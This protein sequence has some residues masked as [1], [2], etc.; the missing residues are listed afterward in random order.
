MKKIITKSGVVGW[1]EKLHKVY[2]SFEEFEVYSNVYGISKRLGYKNAKTCWKAN[3]LI[4]GSV[5]PCD[6]SKSK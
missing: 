2:S 5:Y 1:Q 6:L 3:P 4:E